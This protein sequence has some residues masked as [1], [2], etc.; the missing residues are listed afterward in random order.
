VLEIRLLKIDRLERFLR[1]DA[2]A[3][4]DQIGLASRSTRDSATL[5]EWDTSPRGLE[6]TSR[7]LFMGLSF[8]A[9]EGTI[10]A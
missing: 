4:L 9:G 6:V 10:N 7:M 1:V 3:R 8:G 2:A 5:V